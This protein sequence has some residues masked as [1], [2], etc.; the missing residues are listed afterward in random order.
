LEKCFVK[1]YKR[2]EHILPL[3]GQEEEELEELEFEHNDVPSRPPSP[4]ER[5]RFDAA[6]VA[7]YLAEAMA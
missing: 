3:F 6:E 2:M 4:H 7:W 5:G 1:K